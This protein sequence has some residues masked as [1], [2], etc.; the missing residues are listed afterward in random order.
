MK[1][2]KDLNQVMDSY[3]NSNQSNFTPFTRMKALEE[4][5]RLTNLLNEDAPTLNQFDITMPSNGI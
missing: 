4:V 3:C 2:S 5:D 1:E